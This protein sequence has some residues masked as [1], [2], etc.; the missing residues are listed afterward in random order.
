MPDG[1]PWNRHTFRWHVYVYGAK[2]AGL[3]TLDM[4]NKKILSG[5]PPRPYLNRHTK[6]TRLLVEDGNDVM[7][8][9]GLLGI[10]P[11][12]LKVYAHSNEVRMKE[13]AIRSLEKKKTRRRA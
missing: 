5:K 10:T 7:T 2:P 8:V 12:I 9:S 13:A 3:L 6:A 11:E 4:K 1:S